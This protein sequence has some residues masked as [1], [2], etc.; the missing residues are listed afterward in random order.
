MPLVEQPA[1][2]E[3]PGQRPDGE[4]APAESEEVHAV[5]ALVALHE[6]AVGVLD[7]PLEAPAR[8]LVAHGTETSRLLVVLPA[9]RADAGVVVRDL[10]LVLLDERVR[11]DHVRVVAPVFVAGSVAADD[12]VLHR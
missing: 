1:L 9:A 12:D 7:V 8:H 2:V 10:G 6:T 3:H 5:A 11:L 4:C